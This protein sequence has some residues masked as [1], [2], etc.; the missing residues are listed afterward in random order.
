MAFAENAPPRLWEVTGKSEQGMAG[1]FYILP[2]THNGLD[3]EY[4]EYF[5][6]VVMPIALKADA[7]LQES[8]TLSPR[9]VPACAAPLAETDEN[10]KILRQAY[11]DV[12]RA[13]YDLRTPI[14][15]EEW[16]SDQDWSDVQEIE[17]RFA[18]DPTAK[19]T[20]YGL[21][22]EMGTLLFN[23]QLH[24]PELFP[25]VDYTVSPDIADYIAHERWLKGIKKNESI[26][27]SSD[28]YDI[29]CAI[30]PRQR[31]RYLQQKIAESDPALFKPMSKGTRELA[32]AAYVE[33][34]R[35]GYLTGLLEDHADDEYSRHAVCDRND[36]WI[37]KMRQ[38]LN[39]G[40]RFYALGGAH[41]LEP[42]L[43]NPT[44]C[45]GLLTRLRHEGYTVTLLR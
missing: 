1:K 10:R 30:G 4:D 44:R 16:M 36:K 21:V 6:K 5:H 15:R 34:I 29:Y 32:N 7:F 38:G 13:A 8:A 28:L 41:V 39:E 25:K 26:D 11:L 40:I 17:H 45:D 9:E 24:H 43:G 12:E 22:V 31:G 3:V 20:E 27:Q 37:A 23:K 14:P 33:S 35:K 42:G 2:V 18:H 19:L